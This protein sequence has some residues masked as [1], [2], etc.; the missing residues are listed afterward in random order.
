ME[1]SGILSSHHHAHGKKG[2]NHGE[3]AQKPHFPVK[4]KQHHY[5]CNRRD[6][7][8]GQVGELMSQQIFR[9]SGIV[10]NQFSETT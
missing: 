9:E 8:S 6:Y 3:Q 5:T 4:E 10:I 2:E 1:K 7:G